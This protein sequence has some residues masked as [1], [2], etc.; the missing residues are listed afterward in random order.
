MCNWFHQPYRNFGKTPAQSLAEMTARR[1]ELAAEC[2]K[3]EKTYREDNGALIEE[4]K[5]KDWVIASMARTMDDLRCQSEI[6]R[7]LYGRTKDDL[8]AANKRLAELEQQLSQG[9][10]VVDQQHHKPS[11][12]G[13]SPDPAT[14]NAS[15]DVGAGG[16]P[17]S[18]SSPSPLLGASPADKSQ[19][20]GEHGV[21]YYTARAGALAAEHWTRLY[22]K[23]KAYRAAERTRTG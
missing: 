9:S 21:G 3:W 23:R 20:A 12:V 13:S 2:A 10:S 7:R 1:N 15:L 4:I 17:T 11:V 6:C 16:R 19:A 22:Y 18:F 8:D 14:N 5:T